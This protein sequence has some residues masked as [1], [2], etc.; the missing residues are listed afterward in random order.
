MKEVKEVN[1]KVRISD[2]MKQQILT[3]CED[4]EL[5]MSQFIRLAIKEYLEKK[6]D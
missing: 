1:I 3:Y 5:N 2:A 6:V 4:S